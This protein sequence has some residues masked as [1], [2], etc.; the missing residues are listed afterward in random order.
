ML[1][2]LPYKL[3]DLHMGQLDPGLVKVVLADWEVMG[4]SCTLSMVKK[5]W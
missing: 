4:V 5:V 3:L 1:V 2:A